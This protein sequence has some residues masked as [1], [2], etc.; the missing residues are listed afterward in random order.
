V[1]EYGLEVWGVALALLGEVLG[2]VLGLALA[3]LW[4][5]WGLALFGVK[6]K[7]LVF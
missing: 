4:E 2:L 5:V 6:V 1:G 7:I 3:L